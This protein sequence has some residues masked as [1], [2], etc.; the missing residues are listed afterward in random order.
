MEARRTIHDLVR[1]I[2]VRPVRERNPVLPAA[3]QSAILVSEEDRSLA[4]HMLVE[5][6]KNNPEYKEPGKQLKRIFKSSKEK[7]K[8]QDPNLWV[9]SQEELDQA[10]SSVIE[11]PATN[12]G[13]IQAFLN[14]G[15]KVNFVEIYGKKN[16][17][18]QTSN[19]ARRRSTVLQRAATTRRADSVSLLAGSGADQTT[20]DEGL[21]VA[22]G[23][24]DYPCVQEL[25]RHGADPGKF[26]NALADAVRSGDQ[27][28]VQLLLRAPKALRTDVIS[29]CLP[30]AVNQQSEPIISLLVGHGADPNFDNASAFQMAISQRDFKLAV[31]LV[32]GPT[33]LS[34][35]S[36]QTLLGPTLTLPNPQ[37]LYNFL[38][39]LFCC[40]LPPSSPHLAEL[41]IA[42]T[43]RND[44]GM[45]QLLLTNGVST[46][47]NQAECLRNAIENKNWP[48]SDKIL[49]SSIS[50]AQAS[51]ALAVVSPETAPP[52]RLHVITALVSHGAKGKPLQRWLV[53]AVED[54][55]AALMDLLMKADTSIA[56]ENSHAIQT[57][58]ARK[59]FNSLRMLLRSRPSP[60]SL[61]KAFTQITS[62]YTA[63]ERIEVVEI[64]LHH[65]AR[66]PEVDQALID[67][68]GDTTS[69]DISLVK[70]LVLNGANVNF[71]A[72]K[73]IHLA[74]T[75]RD[76]DI[77]RLLCSTAPSSYAT[78]TALP[79]TMDS[80]GLKN[81][82]TITMMNILLGNGLDDGPVNQT[83]KIA[84][85]GGTANIDIIELF[86]AKDPRLSKP[87]FEYASS[88]DNVDMKIPIMRTLLT[89]G[90]PQDALDR[91]LA[92]ETKSALASRNKALVEL[93]I[94]H[95]ASVLENDGEAFQTAV[96]SADTSL[97][98]LLLGGRDR[99]SG[100]IVTKAFLAL[101]YDYKSHCSSGKLENCMEIAQELLDRGV[102]QSAIDSVLPT[103]LDPANFTANDQQLIDLLLRNHAN[104]C[105]F[106]PA[107]SPSA[108]LHPTSA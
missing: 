91:A 40:G 6:R 57:A 31:A 62:G 4:R 72:G 23:A 104:L 10:L 92:V 58:V 66:G 30:A 64:L 49:H 29:S 52:E 18:N 12:P 35:S 69:R 107:S 5:Q 51:V 43:K 88:L 87:A 74:V 24:H 7:E 75:Q 90:I 54:G 59:D 41:L 27:N 11:N 61:S 82:A 96:S 25:L 50:P 8:L 44:T 15:A 21:K 68:V 17:A 70:E 13:L 84:I 105:A 100:S 19:A 34:S 28:F 83:L 73:A 78:S 76:V 45:A 20:L 108:K 65:G 46:E 42:A 99:P 101:F 97:V 2:G 86:I 36:L 94:D 38:E 16:K 63:V 80:N 37:I 103:V 3:S 60:Q 22:L 9:F 79:L 47:L 33:P 14:L 32:A 85:Q 93:L 81:S 89:K 71:E 102:D 26:P 77:L 56:S 48:I 95:G 67:A 39:L 1:E 55:D 98:K 106:R 53:R